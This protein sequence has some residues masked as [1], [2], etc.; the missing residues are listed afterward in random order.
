M[1]ENRKNL[2]GRI[3]S[4][5]MDKTVVVVVETRKPHPLYHRIIRTTRRFQAHDEENTCLIGDMVRIVEAR[6]FSKNKRWQVAEVLIKS[7]LGDLQPKDIG[8]P[9]TN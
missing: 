6:P 8:A 2:V 1:R 7:Q 5:K 9:P 4:N 3:A